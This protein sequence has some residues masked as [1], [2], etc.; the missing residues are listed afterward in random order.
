MYGGLFSGGKIRFHSVDACSESEYGDHS[1]KYEIC[2][3]LRIKCFH[4]LPAFADYVFLHEAADI[5]PKQKQYHQD[6]VDCTFEKCYD[7]GI[8]RGDV[9]AEAAEDTEA[10]IGVFVQR[11]RVKCRYTDI[12][13]RKVVEQDE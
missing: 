10:V 1:R 13:S 12:Y 9:Y 5:G 6:I 7:G 8:L 4:V 2:D 11:H 3:V